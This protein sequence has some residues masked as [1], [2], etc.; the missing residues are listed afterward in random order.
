MH[1]NFRFTDNQLDY[2]SATYIRLTKPTFQC[3]AFDCLHCN[4]NEPSLKLTANDCPFSLK[5]PPHSYGS[6]LTTIQNSP[7]LRTNSLSLS[8][9]HYPYSCRPIQSTNISTPTPYIRPEL[10][11]HQFTPPH[12]KRRDFSAVCSPRNTFAAPTR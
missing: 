1:H 4:T 2:R 7:H 3:V 10:P 5:S 12:Q 9:F 11:E 8:P 6:A